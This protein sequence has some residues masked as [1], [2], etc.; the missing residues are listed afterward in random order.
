MT[1]S[2]L[3]MSALLPSSFQNKFVRGVL[4]QRF[5][6]FYKHIENQSQWISPN[7]FLKVGISNGSVKILITIIDLIQL[8]PPLI[9]H[10][11]KSRFT[12]QMNNPPR[13]LPF[14]RPR[15]Q[16]N[17]NRSNRGRSLIERY[18]AFIQ[19]LESYDDPISLSGLSKIIQIDIFSL[20]NY[21]S[22]A[23]LVNSK[24]ELIVKHT[25]NLIHPSKFEFKKGMRILLQLRRNES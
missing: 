6:R 4:Y 8:A 23:E 1:H 17:T 20:R 7:S 24:L 13:K 19:Y 21:V 2:D 5:C 14:I 18:T 3:P 11:T 12:I 22:I 25:N 9:I 15:K 10:D 16:F